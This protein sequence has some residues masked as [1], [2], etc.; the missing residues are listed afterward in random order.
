MTNIV[1]ASAR[2][3]AGGLRLILAGAKKRVMNDLAAAFT[4]P[5][6]DNAATLG[7]DL[8]LQMSIALRHF[9]G[10]ARPNLGAP[11]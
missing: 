5:K 4:V 7:A 6:L 11:R 3:F 2:S 1:R 10:A 8:S 9:H